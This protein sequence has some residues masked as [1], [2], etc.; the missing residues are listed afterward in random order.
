MIEIINGFPPTVAPFRATGTITENDYIQ[1]INPL[2]DKIYKEYGKINYLL[3]INTPLNNFSAGAW[4]KDALLGFV[5]FTDWRKI[6]IVS[7]KESIKDFTNLFGKLI[8]GKTKGF[9]MK[10]LG[11]AEK[12]VSE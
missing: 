2:I 12:W 4:I 9:M 8:P 11:I 3:V 6:A 7:D 1:T 10:D 5:Y